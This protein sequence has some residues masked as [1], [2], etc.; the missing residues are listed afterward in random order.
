VS[1]MAELEALAVTG[2]TRWGLKSSGKIKGSEMAY[3]RPNST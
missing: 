2:R 1:D 3:E